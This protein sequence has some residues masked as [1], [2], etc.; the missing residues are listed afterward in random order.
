MRIC[1]PFQSM[2]M[3]ATQ[4]SIQAQTCVG[5]DAWCILWMY[6]Y[7]QMQEMYPK[8]KKI[9]GRR[10]PT[11]I[12]KR[13]RNQIRSR[14]PMRI[15]KISFITNITWHHRSG[16]YTCICVA[17]NRNR[18]MKR[19]RPICHKLFTILFICHQAS[20]MKEYWWFSWTYNVNTYS[21]KIC[22]RRRNVKELF[23]ITAFQNRGGLLKH[24]GSPGVIN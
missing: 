12:K 19:M 24:S 21:D 15:Q 5:I 10:P 3:A 11:E 4:S 8:L 6:T 16:I 20:Q 18:W 7:W 9:I 13:P 2:S 1:V 23:T 17:I 22:Q 14:L